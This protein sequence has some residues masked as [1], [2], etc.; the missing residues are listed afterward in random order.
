M[1]TITVVVK[2]PN[3]LKRMDRV[4]SQVLRSPNV[5]MK[6]LATEVSK[7][8]S[9]S[10]ASEGLIDKGYL[11]KHIKPVRVGKGKYVIQMPRYG[12]WVSD[13][14][15]KSHRYVPI[16]PGTHIE[17]W[18]RRH[19]IPESVKVLKTR[20]HPFIQRAMSSNQLVKAGANT[21]KKRIDDIIKRY[22]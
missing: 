1:T 8:L 17:D 13:F 7:I 2:N 20:E 5:F 3:D 22:K 6:D 16:K 10:A 19:G 12:D 4:I 9:K 21:I 11:V 15:G 18:A 14:R